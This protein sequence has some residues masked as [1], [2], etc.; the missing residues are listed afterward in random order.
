[1]LKPILY[2]ASVSPFVRKVQMA[3]AE[4]HVDYELKETLPKKLLEAT[5]QP[6]PGEFAAISP[7]GKIPGLIDGD[8]KISESSIIV[9][10]LDKKHN[11]NLYPTA[12]ALLA[13]ALW[14]ERYAD[15]ELSAV[16]H[17]QI[18]CEE[19]IKPHV[20]KTS[21]D[22]RVVQQAKTVALPKILDYLDTSLA[23]KS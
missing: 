3:M 18:F 13:K 23:D 15:E 21:P 2:G 10:Y 20:L 16:V 17:K 5:N 7:A 22:A 9:K 11:G 14:F 1:M 19:F 6:V 4:L 12:P 8:L